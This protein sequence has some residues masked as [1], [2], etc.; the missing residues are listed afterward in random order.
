MPVRSLAAILSLALMAVARGATRAT[1]QASPAAGPSPLAAPVVLT[2]DAPAYG[3]TYGE[4]SA[5]QWQWLR[6]FPEELS[7]YTDETGEHC[8]FGQSGS[9]FFP[10]GTA[11]GRGSPGDCTLPAGVALF[12][13]LLDSECSSVEAP[14]AFGRDEAELAA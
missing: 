5:R 11:H 13:P 12:V 6:S 8:G 2:P 14:P 1:G 7:P 9:V 4:W 3:A 10:T